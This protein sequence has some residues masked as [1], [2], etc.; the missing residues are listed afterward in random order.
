MTMPVSAANSRT[1]LVAMPTRPKPRWTPK[2]NGGE[3]HRQL[4]HPQPEYRLD[5]A[6]GGRAG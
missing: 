2:F 4:D 3:E 1:R 6:A 5:R